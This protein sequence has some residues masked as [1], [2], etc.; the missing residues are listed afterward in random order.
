M[1]T[2]SVVKPS[3]TIV[4]AVVDLMRTKRS[5]DDRVQVEK[6]WSDST[7]MVKKD[8]CITERRHVQGTNGSVG[9]EMDIRCS[10]GPVP[11][12][13][14]LKLLLHVPFDT[15]MSAKV[16]GQTN[17]TWRRYTHSNKC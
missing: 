1:L 3:K 8:V 14:K 4:P 16:K 9:C 11:L 7:L 10:P 5:S 15:T 12:I 6:I 13:V 17:Y 2:V